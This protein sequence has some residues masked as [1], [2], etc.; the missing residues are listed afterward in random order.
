[1]AL[2]T[3][4][5]AIQLTTTGTFTGASRL[6]PLLSITHYCFF[7]LYQSCLYL[8]AAHT[9]VTLAHAAPETRPR[10][11]E[12]TVTA[13]KRSEPLQEI[14]I[15]L[16]AF[17]EERLD[18]EGING[19]K[20]IHSLVPSL[21]IEPFPINNGTLRVFIRGIGISDAQITQDPPVGVYLDGVYI[22]RS[23]G[24]AMDVAD[25]ERIEVLRGPQGTLY[26]RNTTGGAINL[27]TSRPSTE[28]FSVKQ[29]LSTGS[30]NLFSSKTS[31]NVPI[32]D[33]LA[34]KFGALFAQQDGYVDNTG[35]GGDF[36]DS[37]L[38]GYRLDLRW[39][40]TDSL[41]VDYAYDRSEIDYYNNHYQHIR[42]RTPVAGS[43]ADLINAQ[44]SSVYATNFKDEL[45]TVTPFQ[46][47]YTEIEGHALTIS[48]DFDTLQVKYIGSYRQLFDE[49]YADLGGGRGLSA[50]Q[51]AHGINNQSKSVFRLDTSPY[52]GQA[53]RLVAGPGQ[54]TPLVKPIVDQQQW[55]H[56]LQLSGELFE[57]RLKY[58][59]GAYYFYEEAVEDNGPLHHQLSGPAN[60]GVPNFEE[61]FGQ[62]PILGGVISDLLNT[63][64]SIRAVNFLSQR[65]DIENEAMALYGQLT[66]TPPLWQDRLHLTLGLRHSEDQRQAIKNQQ[67][68]T[69]IETAAVPIDVTAALCGDGTA[70]CR[71]FNNLSASQ[72][73]SNDAIS[74]IAAADI[75]ESSTLYIKMVEAYK[76]GG[77]NTR[78]PQRDGK[79]GEASD[80]IDYGFGYAEGFAPEYVTSYELGFK[81]ELFRHRLR[82]NADVF[83]SDYQDMQLNFI[84][85]GTV[86]DTKV[87]NAG[88]AEMW[89]FES[90]ITY[91][92][93]RDLMLMFSYAY[94]NTEVTKATDIN[95]ADASDQFVFF[96]APENSFSFAADYTV[97]AR[98]WGRVSLNL[99]WN[100]LDER[101]GG[102]RS[103]NIKNT[104]LRAYDLLNARLTLSDVP[105]S[106]GNMGI[107]IWAKNILDEEY[108]VSAIDNLPEADRSVIW[109]EPAS[110]GIDLYYR[111]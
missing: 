103:D 3:A 40:A 92:F 33:N 17:S 99:G 44:P 68:I 83:F 105:L 15:S 64:T 8:L 110:Y 76:S 80:G 55:S 45:A 16:A 63:G 27:I 42:P 7:R 21:T 19:L 77:F 70:S 82:V 53:A 31:I 57:Q 79:Q 36:G 23:T 111:F 96:S 61:T 13:Q 88:E 86:A 51:D 14:P 89:G 67:D 108:E 73:F 20:D 100:Y 28:K 32:T 81:T 101:N 94:L 41:S 35:P 5:R 106:G 50:G 38:N 56:E 30:R 11:E 72:D 85:A 71:E 93:N 10:L 95:G 25:L 4:N 39:S 47:S 74:L 78:D 75:A 107:A 54:C 12:V 69:I 62:V 90:D 22:A 26:G 109:G 6:Q 24:A 52:C 91:L 60:L 43:Q 29:K 9:T 34:V 87:T 102:S 1:M 104:E 84:L 49:S 2:P 65:Y 37:D 18:V 48:H 58:I 97:L 46:G 66:W 59:L 98:D